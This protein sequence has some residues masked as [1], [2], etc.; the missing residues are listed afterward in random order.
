MGREGPSC[1]SVFDARRAPGNGSLA[2][3]G[4]LVGS[5]SSR[6]GRHLFL[7]SFVADD[8]VV[9]VIHPGTT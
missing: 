3:T 9:V 4:V 1:V 7:F 2:F 6:S 8:D 5:W